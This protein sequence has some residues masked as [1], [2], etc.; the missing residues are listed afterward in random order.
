MPA[1]NSSKY[2][3]QAIESILNQTVSDF[4]LIIIDDGSTDDTLDIIRKYADQD[5]RIVLIQNAHGGAAAARNSGL[6]AAQYPWIALL[7]SDDIALPNRFERQLEAIK[8]N[9]E[10]VIWGSFVSHI[11]SKGEI[12]SIHKVGPITETDFQRMIECGQVPQVINPTVI[13]KKEIVEKAGGY[14]TAFPPAEDTEL[15]DRMAEYGPI[16]AIPEVLT[17]YRI[18]G[19]SLSMEKFFVQR[20]LSRYVRLRRRN[21]RDGIETPTLEEYLRIE[22]QKPLIDRLKQMRSDYYVYYYRTAGY[23][24]AQNQYLR[25]VFYFAL[26]ALLNPKYALKRVWNQKLSH[27]MNSEN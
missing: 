16:L 12:L 24:Y 20:K 2:I 3:C 14:N 8:S 5:S 6:K 10:V 11:N 1:Y 13:M 9:P 22:A 17:Y 21:R 26:S 19:A 27:M 7:D 25:A 18:H 4:E 15:F 23:K